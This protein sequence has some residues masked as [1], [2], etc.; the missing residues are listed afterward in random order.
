MAKPI[1][2]VVVS[3]PVVT[4]TPAVVQPAPA[5]TPIQSASGKPD[6]LTKIEGIG[7]KMSQALIKAGI[8]TFAKLAQASEDQLKTAIEAAG[9]RLAPSLATWPEQAVFAANGDWDG[10]EA[11][12]DTL[13]GGRRVD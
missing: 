10:L 11:L 7:P 13:V 1:T 2:P 5:P 4:A 9:M 6:D 8:D 3:K 12:Q